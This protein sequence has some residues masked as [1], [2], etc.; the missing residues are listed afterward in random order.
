MFGVLKGALPSLMAKV[1]NVYGDDDLMLDPDLQVKEVTHIHKDTPAISR[2]NGAED[3]LTPRTQI[4]LCEMIYEH[5][6]RRNPRH[7]LLGFQ[8]AGIVPLD[9]DL[10]FRACRDFKEPAHNLQPAEAM[11]TRKSVQSAIEDVEDILQDHSIS[12]LRK[13]RRISD[14]ASS[15][16][17][18]LFPPAHTF[19]RKEGSQPI[20]TGTQLSIVGC[21]SIDELRA[22]MLELNKEKEKKSEEKKAAKEA[23]R[24]AKRAQ[25]GAAQEAKRAEQ[26]AKRAER[27]AAHEAKRAAKVAKRAERRADQEKRELAQAAKKKGLAEKTARRAPQAGNAPR[28]ELVQNK[29]RG[30]GGSRS[31]VQTVREGPQNKSAPSSE[32]PEAQHAVPQRS[33]ERARK[34]LRKMD[35]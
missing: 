23:E 3:K 20:D 31:K 18:A 6:L 9:P 10:I 2:A 28:G 15:A 8:R 32:T 4:F 5:H 14:V 22:R 12:P 13:I 11:P 29:A 17:V 34:P 26:E 16:S 7:G 1:M 25:R 19:R 27:G 33:R 30:R 35:L 24:E 21:T